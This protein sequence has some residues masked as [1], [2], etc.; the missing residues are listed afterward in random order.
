MMR[1]PSVLLVLAFWCIACLPAVG[2]DKYKDSDGGP[3]SEWR[4][5][6]PSLSLFDMTI[7]EEP[8]SANVLDVV[9]IGV[10]GNAD[11]DI[12]LGIASSV[13]GLGPVVK[14]DLMS[15]GSLFVVIFRTPGKYVV[16]LIGKAKGDAAEKGVPVA[17]WRVSVA[18]DPDHV[19][20]L[21]AEPAVI[22]E[23][24]LAKQSA[25]GLREFLGLC[26][27][28]GNRKRN[29]ALAALYSVL[30]GSDAGKARILR[31]LLSQASLDTE[32]ASAVLQRSMEED[33]IDV[34]TWV[35]KTWPL[36]IRPGKDGATLFHSL[37]NFMSAMSNPIKDET[38][39]ARL[40]I[41]G[42]VDINARRVGGATALHDAAMRDSM[43]S[44]LVAYVDLGADPELGDDDGNTPLSLAIQY[45]AV[46]NAEYLRAK[47]PR[48]YTHEFPVSNDSAA[49]KAVLSA[50][51]SALRSL[52]LESFSEMTARTQNKVPASSLHLAAES[53][54]L[55]AVR[56]LVKR[57]VD[58]N[59]A[60]RYGRSPLYYSIFSGRTDVSLEL[61]KNGA[62][63]NYAPVGASADDLSPF[64][65]AL[66]QYPDFALVMLQKGYKPQGAKTAMEAVYSESLPLVKALKSSV[67]W[68]RKEIDLAANLGLVDI[69]EYLAERLSLSESDRTG[70]IQKAKENQE[71][72]AQYVS[73]RKLLA[74]VFRER[75]SEQRVRGTFMKS[76]DSWSPWS[77][78]GKANIAKYPVGVYVPPSY[79]GSK[80]YGLVV[81]MTNA[82]SKSPY[83]GNF[84]T[85]LDERKLIW[86]GFDPYTH[87]MQGKDNAL[88]CLAVVYAVAREYS[89][90]PSRIYIGGFSLGGQLSRTAILSESWP[91]TGSF[92]LNIS[93]H[94]GPDDS[95]QWR[96][97]RKH[98]PM[99][100][101]S[102]DYDYNRASSSW[103]YE[104]QLS[105]GYRHAAYM[106]VPM[107]GHR[108]VPAETFDA[109]ISYLDSFSH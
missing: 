57:R 64:D 79:D 11:I 43:N 21:L 25:S 24:A 41:Q 84:S 56:A 1:K 89:L 83:P 69:A 77:S 29:A 108:L 60:D 58:W 62:D 13:G 52:P 26:K 12:Q 34:G 63:P 65:L 80:P 91:F 15:G 30:F 104:R 81:S 38:K 32:L 101:V 73:K 55:Q 22:L 28:I 9:Y 74:E 20:A 7:L 76:L 3:A 10:Q 37:A 82:K 71:S 87:M 50:D 72:F 103:S 40:F 70:I 102:G 109:I 16:S 59:V 67:V 106:H 33:R 31:E 5:I 88:F 97:A 90:D 92:F 93:N 66:A 6:Y 78:P 96:Y 51:L 2:R 100:I 68:S 19:A 45:G 14:T 39:W 85:T 8:K 99:V 107:Q 4:T 47:S 35:I 105:C 95:L 94:P 17:E 48:M 42:G 49:C 53:G 44:L 86:V 98:I 18:T 23:S 54:S 36:A 75:A 61:L 46:K 27:D